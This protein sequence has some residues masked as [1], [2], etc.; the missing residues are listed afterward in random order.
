M[1]NRFLTLFR[2]SS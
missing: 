1:I 2:S